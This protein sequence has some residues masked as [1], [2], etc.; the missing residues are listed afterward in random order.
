MMDER[1]IKETVLAQ[2]NLQPGD[3]DWM[4]HW[5]PEAFE[6]FK[7]AE[8]LAASVSMAYGHGLRV[9]DEAEFEELHGED[10]DE[11]GD[12]P[13]AIVFQDVQLSGVLVWER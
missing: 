5:Y 1:V 3:V 4:L 6:G 10:I 7:D 8:A 12:L 2:T 13:G 9:M 11:Y